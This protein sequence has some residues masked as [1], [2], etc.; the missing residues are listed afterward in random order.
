MATAARFLDK[1]NITLLSKAVHHHTKDLPLNTVRIQTVALA[2]PE[3]KEVLLALRLSLPA[4]P[5]TPDAILFIENNN[6]EKRVVLLGGLEQ[7]KA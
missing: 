5:D 4:L 2:F 6:K 7:P 3:R 1:E